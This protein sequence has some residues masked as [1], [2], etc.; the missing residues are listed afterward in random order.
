MASLR[1]MDRATRT[2]LVWLFLLLLSNNCYIHVSGD[3][4]V[5]GD[6]CPPDGTPNEDGVCIIHTKSSTTDVTT[7]SV[8][9]LWDVNDGWILSGNSINRFHIVPGLISDVMIPWKQHSSRA[10]PRWGRHHYFFRNPNASPNESSEFIFAP[11]YKYPLECH[12][13]HAN[14]AVNY[15][16]I[17][18]NAFA[19]SQSNNVV[20]LN[21]PIRTDRTI[22]VGD[23]V[24]L[25]CIDPTLSAH[26]EYEKFPDAGM[27]T[28]ELVDTGDFCINKYN[29]YIKEMEIGNADTSER[30]FGTFTKDD[31]EEGSAILWG[32][33]VPM[34]RSELRDPVT[35]VDELLLNYCYAPS[36]NNYTSPLLLLPM[37]PGANG[38]NHADSTKGQT[39]NVAISWMEPQF[40]PEKYFQKPTEI[41]F[42]DAERSETRA[43]LLI[44]YVV[45]N[46]Y[47][48][49]VWNGKK[50]GMHIH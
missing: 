30:Y 26:E 9:P 20:T 40:D 13:H 41:L 6:D 31:I 22:A 24:F 42:G 7:T 36:G 3:E 46:C 44:E 49:M 2:M 18:V 43:P 15:T 25:P 45:R 19:E 39:P 10:F 16:D 33:F 37:V 12:K 21:P 35:N 50:R 34:H 38:I 8:C 17:F 5:G 47:W 11:G 27:T 23:P 28:E 32:T 4:N 1:A 29:I 48:I 14:L